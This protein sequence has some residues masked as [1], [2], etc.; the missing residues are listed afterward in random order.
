MEITKEMLLKAMCTKNVP[1]TGH[2]EAAEK[3]WKKLEQMA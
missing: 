2:A 1:C 3:V